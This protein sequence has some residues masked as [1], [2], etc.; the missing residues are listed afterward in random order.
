MSSHLMGGGLGLFDCDNDEGTKSNR[1]ANGARLTNIRLGSAMGPGNDVARQER[2]KVEAPQLEL[3]RDDVQNQNISALAF[4][5]VLMAVETHGHERRVYAG[6]QT[7][8]TLL[9]RPSPMRSDKVLL[10]SC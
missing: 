9:D 3:R 7:A 4:R 1:A 10:E 5:P 8:A 2:I 6:G